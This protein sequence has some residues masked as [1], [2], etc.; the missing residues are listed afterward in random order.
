M[1]SCRGRDYLDVQEYGK[2]DESTQEDFVSVPISRR[3]VIKG[4]AALAGVAA[5]G[6]P[7]WILSANG[8]SEEVVPW[9]DIPANFN[10]SP[11]TGL[12]T[13]DTRTIQ[14]STFFTPNEDFFAVQHYPVPN[15]DPASY[16]L[17]LTGLINKPLELTLDEL[18]KRAKLEQVVGFECSG[19]NPQ[20]LNTLVGNARWTGTS[21]NSLLKD[22][23]LKATAREVVFFG[24]DRSTEDIAHGAPKTEQYEQHFGRS[25][26]L[27][28]ANQPE[29]MLAWEMNGAP[30]PPKNG[31]PVRL[32]VPGW[33][34]VSNV[35]WIDHIH[36]QDSRFMGRF[37]ARDYVQ[38]IQT[39]EGEEPVW[40]ESSVSRIR[41]KSM[42]ARLTRTGNRYTATGYVMNDGTPLKSVEVRVDNGSWQPVSMEKINTQYSWK[43]FTYSWTGLAA[44]DHTIVSRATDINGTTQPEEA[45]LQT[46]KTRWE[47]NAQ[48]TRKFKV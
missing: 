27:E 35:K 14:K 3:T 36:V 7:E 37:M 22:V 30:L 48:F 43:L 15:V 13:L 38:L 18:K 2:N 1:S 17:R 23:G 46:K 11:A 39:K 42:V 10:P 47:N 4:G 41:I 28:D 24:V 44:G 5:F 25:L 12:R 20:R 33:Y 6:W 45:D 40:N 8:Q 19:N 16:K 31:G 9:T 26:A 29:V 21:L 34:G 32:I